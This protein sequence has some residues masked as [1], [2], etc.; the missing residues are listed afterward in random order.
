MEARLKA[1]ESKWVG[2]GPL[3][4]PDPRPRMQNKKKMVSYDG[5]KTMNHSAPTPWPGSLPLFSSLDRMGAIAP[6]NLRLVIILLRG[7]G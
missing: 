4:N 1:L 2:N 7:I 6:L 5:C 3:K